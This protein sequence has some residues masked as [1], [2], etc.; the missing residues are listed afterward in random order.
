MHGQQTSYEP[1]TRANACG[2]R[3]GQDH[4]GVHRIQAVH[5]DI[6]EQPLPG[7]AGVTAM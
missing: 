4:L 5:R 1:L 7:G 6:E 3:A 2:G